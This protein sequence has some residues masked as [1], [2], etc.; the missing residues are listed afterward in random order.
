MK[1][2]RLTLVIIGTLVWIPYMV[3]KYLLH[4]PFPVGWIL[5]IHIPCMVGAL[6]LR[7]LAS[8]RL[9]PER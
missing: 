5:A 6:I 7:L 3:A 8:K 1:R 2:L 9:A 4:D